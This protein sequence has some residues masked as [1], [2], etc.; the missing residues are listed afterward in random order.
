MEGKV[1]GANG[2]EMKKAMV[3]VDPFYRKDPLYLHPSDNSGLQLVSVQLTLDNYLIWSRSMRIALKSKNK[4]GFVD[5]SCKQSED[6]NYDDYLRWSLADTT[7]VAWMVNAMTEELA[8]AYMFASSARDLWMELEDQ[9]GKGNKPKVFHIRRQISSIQQGTE[10]LAAYSNKLKKLWEQLNCLRPRK[11]CVCNGCTCGGYTDLVKSVQ[12]DNLMEFLNG[13]NSTYENAVNNILMMDP[14]PPYNKAYS[15][16]A[17]LEEQKS[18]SMINES[19][20]EASALAMKIMDQQKSSISGSKN[21]NRKEEK[22]NRYCNYCKRTGHFEDDC[23]KKNGYPEWFKALKE[24]REQAVVNNVSN[25]KV[26]V[27]DTT[28][29]VKSS[30]DISDLIQ[31]LRKFMRG[32]SSNEEASTSTSASVNAAYFSDFA[33]T[34]ISTSSNNMNQEKTYGKNTVQLPDGSIKTVI[35]TGSVHI[36]QKMQLKNVFYVLEFNYNLISVNKLAIDSGLICLFNANKCVVQ[37]PL[38]KEIVAVG[39]TEKNLYFLNKKD[40]VTQEN[41]HVLGLKSDE[42]NNKHLDKSLLWH[43]RLGHPSNTVLSKLYFLQDT[44]N[45]NSVCDVCHEAKQTRLFFPLSDTHAETCFDLLHMDIWGPYKNASLSGAKFMLT[46]I[47]D[48]SRS[49]WTYLLQNKGQVVGVITTFLRYIKN[50][51]NAKVKYVRTDNG[52]EFLSSTCQALFT[53]N[54]VVHQKSC[55]YTPQQNGFVERKHRHLN[56]VSRALMFYAGLSDKFWGEAMLCAAYIINRVPNSILKWKTPYEVLT[57]KIP[58][59]A[60]LKVFGCLC[61]VTNTNPHKGKFD[62]RARKCIFLGYPPDFKGYKVYDIVTGD[63]FISRDVVFYENHYPFKDKQVAQER[64]HNF[65]KVHDSFF[66]TDNQM[67]GEGSSSVISADK[68]VLE[69][70]ND[71]VEE[72][73]ACDECAVAPEPQPVTDTALV[74]A[75]VTD[76]TSLRRSDRAKKQPTWMKGYVACSIPQSSSHTPL[77]FPYVTPSCFTDGYLQFMGNVSQE[78]FL[79]SKNIP[80]RLL[81]PLFNSAIKFIERAALISAIPPHILNQVGKAL[82][83]N[84]RNKK[85][86]RSITPPTIINRR[87]KPD[88][89][90]IM[91]RFIARKV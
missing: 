11:K 57:G 49:V 15:V 64:E 62:K 12:S 44:I 22:K 34:S 75:T 19:A 56:Q 87:V 81:I 18:L 82:M 74:P 17:T 31:E 13:L 37:D 23:F 28:Q 68:D 89:E 9:F 25:S 77:A 35:Y 58:D 30:E 36:H 47:D 33:G 86:E 26:E 53:K 2:A 61:Y 66:D 80:K 72:E 50:H 91:I 78:T 39:V 84:P 69:L 67:I 52:S 40:F 16:I 6:Q 90:R 20:A 46:I 70:Q 32:K 24:R 10:S 3:A 59:Y 73:D 38:N 51:F 43:E 48:C 21:Y 55:T 71:V 5:G 54:G 85:S 79:V 8:E 88:P 1:D 65:Q 42:Q 45:T 83:Q 41:K 60:R 76:N 29:K 4:L 14:E 7:V 63:V 27:K